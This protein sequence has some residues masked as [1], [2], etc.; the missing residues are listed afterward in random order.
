MTKRPPASMVRR[1]RT[2]SPGAEHGRDRAVANRH[3]AVHDDVGLDDRQS[4]TRRS[5]SITSQRLFHHVA[6]RVGPAELEEPPEV[7]HVVARL[8]ID[9]SKRISSSLSPARHSTPPFGSMNSAVPKYWRSAGP[10]ASLPTLL[11]PPT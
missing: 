10:P 5:A 3:P 7:A 8:G 9:V 11:T 2:V 4:L 1:A 6:V